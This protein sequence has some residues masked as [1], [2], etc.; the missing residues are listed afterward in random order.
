MAESAEAVVPDK[1][2]SSAV[3]KINKK[4]HKLTKKQ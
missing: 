4:K 2:I 3:F 1:V